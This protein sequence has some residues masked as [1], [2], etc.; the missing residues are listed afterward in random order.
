MKIRVADYIASRLTEFGVKHVFLLSGGMMM[1]LT[2]ALGVEGGL[3]YVCGHHE[4]ASAMAADGYARKSGGVGVC[5]ATSG[6]GATNILTGLVGAWQDSTPMLFLTGQVKS[7]QTIQASGIADLRQFGT[8]EVDIVPIV[9]SVTKYAQLILDPLTIRFHL[10]KAL[11]LAS[12]GRPGPVL[13]DL[14]LDVQG[15][16]IDLDQLEGYT[17]EPLQSENHASS[18]QTV[19]TLLTASKRPLIL[20][21]YGVRCANAVHQLQQLAEKLG[22]PV[23]TTQLGK[24]VMF[25]DH[26]LFVG[27]PGPKGDRAGNFAVQTADLILSLGCSLHSQTTGWENDIFAPD[28]IKIQVDLDPAVLAREQVH[29]SHKIKVDCLTFINT[30][31]VQTVPP[32]NGESWRDCCKSW[33]IRYPVYLE[34]HERNE[35]EINYYHF[36]ESL[37]K[38]LPPNAGV[39]ADAGSAFYVMGQALRL[40]NGQRF[41]SS[42][43]MGAMGFA[44]P[45]SN[46]M[47]VADATSITVCVTGDGSLMTNV[48]ELSTM[49][50]YNLNVKL[51]VINNDGYVSMR[52]TQREFFGGHYVGADGASGVYIPSMESLAKAYKLPFARCTAADLDNVIKNVLSMDGPVMCEVIAMR[53]QKIIPSVASV[54]LVDGRMQSCQIHNM[55]PLLPSEIIEIELIKALNSSDQ[56]LKSL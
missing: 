3:S 41:V 36:V 52:N 42:G 16:L 23:A 20:A 44:L 4:Q 19:V 11:H 50:K 54:K 13:L 47:A 38:S 6:P 5:Y 17:P 32:F 30:M 26:P 10:E 55:S 48:H 31:L 29:V 40:K 39:V 51:F 49:Y 25:Y 28:A 34:P 46:G 56:M 37:S 33:K 9:K 22:I 15:A 35:S 2:D 7:N 8:F 27:H 1:H 53:D 45:T 14:P 12:T 24:D 21:G 43:S 18:I